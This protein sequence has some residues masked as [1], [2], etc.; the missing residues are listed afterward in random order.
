M[1]LSLKRGLKKILLGM[2]TAGTASGPRLILGDWAGWSSRSKS[3][4]RFTVILIVFFKILVFVQAYAAVH[5]LRPS[6]QLAAP[7]RYHAR[8]DARGGSFWNP[9]TIIHR[10]EKLITAWIMTT[11]A[12]SPAERRRGITP[13]A[14]WGRRDPCSVQLCSMVITIFE[15]V[16]VV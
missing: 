16:T 6:P 13:F 9:Q 5:Q 11:A 12:G 14:G 3:L 1:T 15:V 4:F 2:V 10:T 8:R 7:E